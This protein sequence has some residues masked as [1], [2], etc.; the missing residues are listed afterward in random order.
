[1]SALGPSTECP[2][3]HDI[4]EFGQAE[5]HH[6]AATAAACLSVAA[7]AALVAAC[8][9][10]PSLRLPPGT[11][12]PMRAVVTGLQAVAFLLGLVWTHDWVGHGPES[13]ERRRLRSVYD[14]LGTA[15]AMCQL[16][17]LLE[18]MQIV[19]DPFQPNAM[20]A[21]AVLVLGCSGLLTA[22]AEE[23]YADPAVA[24]EVAAAEGAVGLAWS[25]CHYQRLIIWTGRAWNVSFSALA[26][27]MLLELGERLNCGLVSS[28]AARS[29]ACERSSR[30]RPRVLARR[31]LARL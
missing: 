29:R 7:C 19:S 12:V 27:G 23:A 6:G 21:Y 31:S 16:C 9:Y 18:P 2:E 3:F 1:M 28:R 15:S 14:F 25:P 17:I 11:F 5:L 30:L 10:Q 26:L 13:L 8:A 20:R 4:D 24:L 22:L